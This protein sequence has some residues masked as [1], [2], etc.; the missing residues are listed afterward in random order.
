MTTS[1]PKDPKRSG[2]ST[3]PLDE[4]AALQEL[5]TT[6]ITNP[7]LQHM[8]NDREGARLHS[9]VVEINLRH[10][11]GQRETK[12]NV[13]R[14]LRSILEKAGAGGDNTAYQEG[15]PF[16]FQKKSEL[17]GHYIFADLTT[18]QIRKL[19]NW[20][21]GDRL[22]PQ[23]IYKIWEDF[24][25][26]LY[27][28]RSVSTVKADAAR[29]AFGA[30][31]QDIVW[32][33]IDTGVQNHRHFEK[34]Q[35][36]DLSRLGLRHMDFTTPDPKPLDSNE[37]TDENGHG[38]HVAGIIAGETLPASGEDSISGF[39]F[40]MDEESQKRS[41]YVRT[42]R[43]LRGVAP[44]CKIVSLKVV[45]G[46]G[47]PGRSYTR[48]LMTALAHIRDVNGDGPVPR[49]HGVNISL[50]YDFDPMWFA[51]GSSPLCRAVDSLVKSGVMVVVAAGNGGY[52]EKR[53]EIKGTFKG[54]LQLTI[55]DP[56]NAS[57]A[58]TVGSTHGYMPHEYGVSYFSAKG[59]TS[60]GRLKPDL[61]APGEEDSLLCR[62]RVR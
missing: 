50:G 53:T 6:V 2:D 21:T 36:L 38:T 40:R 14:H 10:P 3:T 56:G 23:P 42:A 37:L 20:N 24:A 39:A 28:D 41:G 34:H 4:N 19:I 31:G 43:A 5:D 18:V 49:I 11:D 32:A 33:V 15:H 29:V 61:V 13:M 7:L 8:V 35:N 62:R 59:P 17:G 30:S 12:A 57:L 55:R 27:L 52:G 58:L 9:V 1:D 60:D 45:S 16:L 22:R 46:N 44:Q 47:S 26:D 25:L 48:D 51:C 54:G